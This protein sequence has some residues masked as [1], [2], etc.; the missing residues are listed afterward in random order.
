MND[1]E[2]S[3]ER[4]VYEARKKPDDPIAKVFLE[5]EQRIA[6]LEQ[7][8]EN[9]HK[10]LKEQSKGIKQQAQELAAYREALEKITRTHGSDAAVR[11]A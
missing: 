10:L 3:W 5:T 11:I 8:L 1:D 9:C 6:E 2:V 4:V 7:Q